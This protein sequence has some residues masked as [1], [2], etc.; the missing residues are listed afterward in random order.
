[1]AFD[2]TLQADFAASGRRGRLDF[3]TFA[4]KALK[5]G[6]HLDVE[7]EAESFVKVKLEE[8]EGEAGAGPAAPVVTEAPRPWKRTPVRAAARPW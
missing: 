2:L 1:M 4:G 7:S 8:K 3:K 5:T 6:E